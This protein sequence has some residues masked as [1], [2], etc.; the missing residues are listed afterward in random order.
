MATI[1]FIDGFYTGNQY[2]NTEQMDT[3]A[4]WIASYIDAYHPPDTFPDREGVSKIAFTRVLSALLGNM[5]IEST[6]NPG[7]WESLTVN[8]QR[9]FGLVQ[10][11]PAAKYLDWCRQNSLEAR[12]MESALKRIFW[13]IENE[14]GLSDQWIPLAAFDRATFHD[15]CSGGP[16]NHVWTID[17]LTECFMRCYERPSEEGEKLSLRQ[18]AARHYYNLISGELPPPPGP[19]P[20]YRARGKFWISMRPMHFYK[21]R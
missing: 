10:W 16:G 8:N 12:R 18:E 20:S 7:V 9:G 13:E 11:T 14:G 5:Q 2:L 19:G 17:K 21:R 1:D 15:F 3:N 4:L 6:V